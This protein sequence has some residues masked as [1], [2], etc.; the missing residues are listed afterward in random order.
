M[1]PCW[2]LLMFSRDSS[3]FTP[4]NGWLNGIFIVFQVD[5]LL[6][7][8]SCLCLYILYMLLDDGLRSSKSRQSEEEEDNW[9][10]TC[11]K[12]KYNYK[13]TFLSMEA[14][15]KQ[16]GI[17]NKVKQIIKFLLLFIVILINPLSKS[18]WSGLGSCPHLPLLPTFL[19][20]CFFLKL[21]PLPL[22]QEILHT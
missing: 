5:N 2:E 3:F 9:E 18:S 21:F 16:G 1:L 15:A 19:S 12:L 4:I 22:L 10:I 13:N 14:L 17:A 20:C 6:L 7:L 11:F 8:L